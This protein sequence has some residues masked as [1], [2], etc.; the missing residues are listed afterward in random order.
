MHLAAG[1]P[2]QALPALRR[3]HHLWHDLQAPYEA[4]RARVLLGRACRAM[5]DDEG[6]ALE[7]AA[8]RQ[9]FRQLGAHPDVVLVDA[10]GGARPVDLPL[11]PR[12]VEVL[13]LIAAGRTNRSIARE[14]TLSEKT[15]H[16]HV[17]SILT[18]LGVGSRTAAAAYAYEHGLH[19]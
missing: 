11:S 15:V 12:E 17:S 18:K 7:L 6:A 9:V 19:R 13:R 1:A 3:A 10:L 2:E 8:A 16:R 5:H 4:A 14:L